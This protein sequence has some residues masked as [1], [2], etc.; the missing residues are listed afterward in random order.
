M[1]IKAAP[2]RGNEPSIYTQNKHKMEPIPSE[3]LNDTLVIL[4]T[5]GDPE[6]ALKMVFMYAFNAKANGWWKDINLIIWGPSAR[7]VTENRE[8][9]EKL[10]EMI[11]SGIRVDACKACADQYGVSGKLSAL[12]VDVKFMGVPLTNILK[13]GYRLLTF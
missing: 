4:W 1:V 11:D 10:L 6:V 7:L 3:Q 12:G 13:T 9:Q 5:S 2:A 8:I